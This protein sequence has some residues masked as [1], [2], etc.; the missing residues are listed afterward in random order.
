MLVD[1]RR[2][3]RPER[4]RSFASTAHRPKSG[5]AFVV[6]LALSACAGPAYIEAP[7]YRHY[8]FYEPRVVVVPESAIEPMYNGRTMDLGFQRSGNILS[9]TTI[10]NRGDQGFILGTP[11]K[12]TNYTGVLALDAAAANAG[13][14]PMRLWVTAT[15]RAEDWIILPSKL[16]LLDPTSS[17]AG[18]PLTDYLQPI[19]AVLHPD[20]QVF[21]GHWQYTQLD[22]SREIR[23]QK[24]ATVAFTVGFE[25]T[26][27]LSHLRIEF[28]DTLQHDDSVLHIPD[29]DLFLAS[30][31]DVVST[32]RI[33]LLEMLVRIGAGFAR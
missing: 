3:R 27:S 30:G 21:T 10:P 28:A 22:S 6:M 13:S 31:K 14:I 9:I 7:T 12:V 26:L 16:R 19:P 29:V 23:C 32:R 4:K 20:S 8:Y 33:T 25:M 24:S 5:A 11:G 15:C 18:I 17:S 2:R 1:P